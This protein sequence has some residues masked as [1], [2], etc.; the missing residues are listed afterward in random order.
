[1]E[2]IGGMDLDSGRDMGME[3]GRDEKHES[4]QGRVVWAGV[5]SASSMGEIRPTSGDAQHRASLDG[6]MRISHVRTKV[7][8]NRT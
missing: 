8:K 3:R 1:V 5:A 2:H 6:W 4:G 7:K